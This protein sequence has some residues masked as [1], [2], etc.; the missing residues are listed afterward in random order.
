MSLIA[1]KC[2]K[3]HIYNKQMVIYNEIISQLRK[4]EP[5]ESEM[6]SLYFIQAELTRRIKIGLQRTQSRDC[7]YIRQA[8]PTDSSC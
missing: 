6:S 7:G 4:T 2:A 3:Y 1:S 5:N 8:R